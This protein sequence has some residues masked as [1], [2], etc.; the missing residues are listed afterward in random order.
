MMLIAWGVAVLSRRWLVVLGIAL[1]ADLFL[2]GV[3]R[4]EAL[5]SFMQGDRDVQ[6]VVSLCGL[7]S[8]AIAMVA[9]LALTRSFFV[10]RGELDRR[11]QVIEA[12]AAMTPDW[13]WE[14]DLEGRIIYSSRGVEELLGYSPDQVVGRLS[15]DL[16]VDD[17]QRGVARRLIEDARRAGTGWE[18]TALTWRHHDGSAVILHGAAVPIYREKGRLTGYRGT[19][20]AAV[21]GTDSERALCT[22]RARLTQML[23]V[24]AFDIAL[25]PIVELNTGRV[26]GVEALARFH[27][28][29]APDLWFRDA[30]DCARTLELE[31]RT[32]AAALRLFPHVPEPIYLSINASP[33]LLMNAEFGQCLRESGAPLHQL[34]IEI[35]EHARV[36]DYEELKAA[37]DTLRESGV[38][39]AIDDTGAGYASLNHVLQLHPNIIKLDRTLIA[40][41]NEDRARRSLVTALVLLALDIG[42]TVTGE[43]AETPNQVDALA[44]LGVDY[45]QGYIIAKPTTDQ[46]QW[47]QW[48][49]RRWIQ[50]ASHPATTLRD[51]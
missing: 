28:G 21:A 35:T 18:R 37:V 5:R 33:E 36:A 34:V 51:A 29:R 13:L 45:A 17:E 49:H 46:T 22:A 12:S 3:I 2:S 40:R 30:H 4:V 20:S 7:G 15:G 48:W 41:L 43:G 42:A 9:G 27:D 32:F 16:L 11:A 26:I 24:S 23:D 8:L 10:A 50:P 39:I 47:K 14:T 44:T 25:Q 31:T 1:V 19:R 6:T 38:R